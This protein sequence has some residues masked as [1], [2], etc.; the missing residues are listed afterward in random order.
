LTNQSLN[1]NGLPRIPT[2]IIPTEDRCKDET[3]SQK[4]VEDY[5]KLLELIEL[6]LDRNRDTK[7][8]TDRDD[9]L[10]AKLNARIKMLDNKVQKAEEDL[11]KEQKRNG[12]LESKNQE[13]K[14]KL[15]QMM[16]R[17]STLT[18]DK[19]KQ[20]STKKDTSVKL[21]ET[22]F[23]K[24]EKEMTKLREV[25]KRNSFGFNQKF[26]TNPDFHKFFPMSGVQPAN[27][28]TEQVLSMMHSA[29]TFS[30]QLIEEV[31]VLKDFLANIYGLL[32]R[33]RGLLADQRVVAM[34]TG[35]RSFAETCVQIYEIMVSVIG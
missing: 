2:S 30:K 13:M 18:F 19:S 15:N 34:I 1:L 20:S 21:M 10:K 28:E 23:I 26:D 32:T 24:M 29:K 31:K 4:V 11:F 12:L 16:A 22:E 27:E 5:S 33:R 17:S 14:E 6:L 25:V 35:P 9:D 8:K 7:K 3:E